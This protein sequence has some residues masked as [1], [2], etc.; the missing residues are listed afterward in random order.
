M[1][2]FGDELPVTRIWTL[3]G[4][5]RI[6]ANRKLVSVTS[7]GQSSIALAAPGKGKAKD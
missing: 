2:V 4:F 7:E 1:T 3:S 5:G 6:P